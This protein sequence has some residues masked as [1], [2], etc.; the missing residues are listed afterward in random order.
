MQVQGFVVGTMLDGNKELPIK[1]RG[2][3]MIS[4]N[5]LNFFL[6]PPQDGFDYSS[7]YGEFEVTNQANFISRDAGK[8]QNQCV[9]LG[10]GLSSSHPDTEKFL[11]AKVRKI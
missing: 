5:R 8:R 9:R 3:Q 6:C 11:A 10:F 7:S 1:I 2:C 4:W